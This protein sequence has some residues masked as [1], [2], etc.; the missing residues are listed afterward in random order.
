[1]AETA[2]SPEGLPEFFSD[3]LKLPP[4]E[5]ND[6]SEM[7]PPPPPTSPPLNAETTSNDDSGKNNNRALL[8]YGS[9]PYFRLYHT[10]AQ[11]GMLEHFL[12]FQGPERTLDNEFSDEK[13]KIR[14]SKISDLF[15]DKRYAPKSLFLPSLH[16]EFDTVKELKP[17]S[18]YETTR[19]LC[20][21]FEK[22]RN[23]MEA[24]RTWCVNDQKLRGDAPISAL[25]LMKSSKKDEKFSSLSAFPSHL[26]Y[27]WNLQDCFK[28]I[29]FLFQ[30]DG[31]PAVISQSPSTN[32]LSKDRKTL[33]RKGAGMMGENS[34]KMIQ[35]AETHHMELAENYGYVLSKL[36]NTGG[37]YHEQLSRLVADMGERIEASHQ[38]IL[39]MEKMIFS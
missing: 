10:I 31:L 36:G 24:L 4:Q 9:D 22:S 1:M 7:P 8:W 32:Q 5:T 12:S 25:S 3:Y 33:V 26:I 23:Q 34:M 19:T 39:N 35:M 17:L 18:Q 14:W 16:P 2:S 27:L 20:S 29:Q 13:N 37:K 28:N 21:K 15:N 30:P 38:R 11:L 6:L